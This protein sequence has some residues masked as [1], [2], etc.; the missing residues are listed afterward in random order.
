MTVARHDQRLCGGTVAGLGWG[1]SARRLLQG[2]A[3]AVER[4]QRGYRVASMCVRASKWD[5]CAQVRLADL[6]C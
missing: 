2:G 1:S 4:L 5:V 6:F 3:T